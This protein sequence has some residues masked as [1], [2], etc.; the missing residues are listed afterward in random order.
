MYFPSFED[1]QREAK[2]ANLI[3]ICREILVDMETPISVFKKIEGNNYSFLLE[4]I[5]GG[6][7]WGKYSFIGINPS[8]IFKSKGR[9]VEIIEGGVV[10]ESSEVDDPLVL[11]KKLMGRYRPA[12][13]EG[14]PR[15]FGGAVGYFSYDTVR[16]FEKLPDTTQDELNLPD[17]IFI[18]PE[19][20]LIFDNIKKTTTVVAYAYVNEQKNLKGAYRWAKKKIDTVVKK[21]GRSLKQKK[22]KIKDKGELAVSSNFTKEDFQYMVE[23]AKEYIK[24]G[25]IIQVVLSQLFQTELKIDP[26]NL[27]RALRRINPSPYMFYLK[28]GD[29]SFVGSSP[30][31]LVRV[32][33]KNIELRPLAGTRPRGKDLEE[34]KILEKELRKDPK[35]KA[36][37]IMLVD[38]GRN[39][40]G[41]VAKYGSVKVTELMAVE[42]YSHVMHLDSNVQGILDD[43][44]D[45]YDVL[46]SCFPAGTVSGAPKVRAMEII[47]ELEPSK[48]GPYAGAVGY[49]SFSGNMDFCITIRTLI[50]KGDRIYLQTG[51]GIV[52]DSDPEKEYI[53]TLNKAKGIIEA[54][55]MAKEGLD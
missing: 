11:M 45:I 41:R 53:E 14:L 44:K 37:H 9:K 3:P 13:V 31:I 50:I 29:L 7:T 30:E 52:A 32:E 1:F 20:I 49:F 39:D 12:V 43:N 8:V 40:V 34:D 22:E 28:F 48:R 26:F 23:K 21:L 33:G 6:E 38:L 5:E 24:A 46:R 2:E 35:E 54:V 16:F 47:E 51:A 18:I 4:S 17:T 27:Y 19:T 25:D 15:F 10:Q 42:R 55:E 36:E